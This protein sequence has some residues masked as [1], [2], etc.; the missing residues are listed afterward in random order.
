MLFPLL[1]TAACNLQAVF[2]HLVFCGFHGEIGNL[3]KPM[4]KP[5]LVMNTT[6]TTVLYTSKT[7]SDGTH[8]LMLRLTKNRRIKYISLHISLD[9]KFWD[10]DKSRPKRN[11]PDKERINTLIETKTKELQEQ[12]LDFKTSDKEYTLNTLL[13]KASRKVV[14]QTVGEY[15]NGYIDRLLVANRVGNAKTFQ[16][17]RTSLTK[18]CRSLD[19]YFIDIDAEWLKRYEQWL[20]VERHYSDNSIGIRFRSLRVLYNSAI[21]DGLIKKTDY[22]FDTFKVSRF[23]EATAKR[24][25]TKED[26]RRIMDCEVRTLTKYPKPFL[27]LAKDL[28]LFSY[29]SCG[30]NLTDILHIR[31]ADIV[32]RRLVFNRQKTGKLLSFQL[33][34]AALAIIDKYRQPNAHPQDY[35]FPVLRR[36]VHVTAQQQYGRVQRTN[37][38]INRYLKLIGEHLHLPITLTTYVARHSFATVLKRSGVSTS[39]ISESLGHSSE[40]ITQI[41]LDSFENSQIDAAMQNLL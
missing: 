39:I 27:Q 20:R 25:L 37:K 4:F 12:I 19:F 30:I 2:S 3:F 41:Y 23:K 9:A 6:L 11:C 32:D 34:P 22:P 31:Y 24:S 5:K 38:R 35:I 33:Q 16:E 14:R 8:P 28:F 10:F 18:F 7:L 26:I 17:L 1:F 40:K 13:E 21:T 36:S 29:L 15:L